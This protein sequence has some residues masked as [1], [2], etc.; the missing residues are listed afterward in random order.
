MDLNVLTY[1]VYI[2]V[3]ELISLFWY[4]I[5][6]S[7]VIGIIGYITLVYHAQEVA[8]TSLMA[9]IIIDFL[10]WVCKAIRKKEVSSLKMKL[11]LW[12]FILYMLVILAWYWA[13]MLVF[14]TNVWWGFHYLFILY[15][16]ITELIS[17]VEH[18]NSMWIN[19]PFWKDLKKF[20]SQLSKDTIF[21]MV[22]TNLKLKK[23]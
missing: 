16:W 10:L 23:K 4:K 11:W 12:K 21:D 18:T 15:L 19:L 17:I 22:K 7:T 3:K 1:I 6:V 2:Y 20:Q 14:K 8:T 5:I 9:L 13:D